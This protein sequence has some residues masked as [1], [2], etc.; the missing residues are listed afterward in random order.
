MPRLGSGSCTS[1]SR[2]RVLQRPRRDRGT[3]FSFLGGA[4]RW[5]ELEENVLAEDVSCA[6]GGR[7]LLVHV[8]GAYREEG[9]PSAALMLLILSARLSMPV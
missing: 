1:R 4:Y 8:M 9:R 6:N 3:A 7:L 5:R 2:A